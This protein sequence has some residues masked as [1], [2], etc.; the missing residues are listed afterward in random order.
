[1]S[2]VEGDLS[3][4]RATSD[5]NRGTIHVHFSITHL[6]EPSPREGVGAR[7]DACRNR[8][9]VCIRI[10]SGSRIICSNVTRLVSRRATSFN[11]MNNHPFR[12]LRCRCVS[13]EGNLA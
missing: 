12:I 2:L 11:G 6:V 3:L 4:A 5:L 7:G 1:M 10:R 8:E 9:R 13:G